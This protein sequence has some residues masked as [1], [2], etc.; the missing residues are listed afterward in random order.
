MEIK[1]FENFNSSN[2]KIDA[3][4]GWVN[5]KVDKY[6]NLRLKRYIKVLDNYWISNQQMSPQDKWNLSKKIDALTDYERMRGSSVQVKLSLV[7]I[8]QY[9]REVKENF[10][11]S[12]SGFLIENLVESLVGGQALSGTGKTDVIVKNI[13]QTIGRKKVKYQI[14]LYNEGSDCDIWFPERVR[15]RCDYYCVCY[16]ESGG[17]KFAIM[18]GKNA[19][20]ATYVNKFKR[21]ATK[22][23]FMGEEFKYA[24]EIKEKDIKKYSA[25]DYV[26]INE[27]YFLKSSR[28]ITIGSSE[29]KEYAF[30]TISFSEIE[31]IITSCGE[32]IKKSITEVYDNISELEYLCETI[33]TG[34]SP[35]ERSMSVDKAKKSADIT[36]DRL[37]NNINQLSSQFK[38]STT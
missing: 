17:I 29:I 38:E 25:R 28:Y 3:S 37:K 10:N 5:V 11:A 35:S 30:K 14:K 16:K 32:D 2:N 6:L 24:K 33:I 26:E 4:K 18:N 7:T 8:L 22:G 36:I 34:F 1:K 31:N 13:F 15:D 20:D 9:F 23:I 12:T 27:R 19:Q 21:I